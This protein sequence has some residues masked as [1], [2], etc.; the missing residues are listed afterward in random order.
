[1]YVKYLYLGFLE[2]LQDTGTIP[3]IPL[4][5]INKL[6]MFKEMPDNNLLLED[7]TNK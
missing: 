4:L 7:K 5:R 3:I 2:H 1:M 6:P